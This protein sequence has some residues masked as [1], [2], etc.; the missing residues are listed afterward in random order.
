AACE[1]EDAYACDMLTLPPDD[2]CVTRKS[3]T[4]ATIEQ[5]FAQARVKLLTLTDQVK[6]LLPVD[7]AR[8]LDEQVLKDLIENRF[9]VAVIGQIKAGKS[10]FLSALT[11]NPGLLPTDVNPWTAVI[12][13]MHFGRPGGPTSGAVFRFYS[14][15]DWDSIANK[16]ARFRPL[17]A[18]GQALLRPFK[19][20]KRRNADA[21]EAKLDRQRCQ[22]VAV[23][24]RRL[25]KEL[26]A[27]L[28]GEHC[29]DTI[30]RHLLERYLAAEDRSGDEVADNP[31][32][33]RYSVI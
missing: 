21:E 28:G 7:E 8:L 24:N 25:G 33:G 9:D 18:V 16:G 19:D 6:Q 32:A 20:A 4:A 23:A 31:D 14:A 29:V 13:R 17:K 2:I 1:T 15:E 12:T 30:N 3:M 11:R 26:Q 27:L 10:T 22:A 5:S